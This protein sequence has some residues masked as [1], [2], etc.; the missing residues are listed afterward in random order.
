MSNYFEF[1][2]TLLHELYVVGSITKVILPEWRYSVIDVPS[3]DGDIF[4]GGKY[5]PLEYDITILVHGETVL[6]Y[7]MAKSDL[8]DLLNVRNPVSIKFNADKVGYGMPTSAVQIVDKSMTDGLAT[9]HI[10]CFSPFFYSTE[11]KSFDSDP[12]ALYPLTITN[13]GGEPVKPFMQVG[14]SKDSNFVQLENTR[15]GERIL[16]GNY[17]KLNLPSVTRDTMVLN[18]HCE[19]TASWSASSASIDADRTSGGTIGITQD[20]NCI[21]IATLPSSST[22]TWKGTAV[23]QNLDHA[24]D[25]FDLYCRMNHKSTGKNGDPTNV[26]VQTET[27]TSGTKETYY[28]VT[29]SS[30]NVRKGAGTNHAKVAT[31]SKGYQIFGA[32]V[33]K[34]WVKF[35]YPNTATGVYRYCSADYVTKKVKDNT[36]TTTKENWVTT[37]PTPIRADAKITATNKGAIPAGRVVR[38]IS[39]KTYSHTHGGKTYQFFKLAV[40]WESGGK[41]YDGYVCNGNIVRGDKATIEY[42][43]SIITNSA[44]DKTGLIELYGFSANGTKLFKIGLIDDNKWY[45]YTCPTFQI[46][47][48][49]VL[50]DNTKVP[51]PKSG[52]TSSGTADSS[53]TVKVT[54]Y[55]SGALGNWNDFFGELKIK[56]T[57]DKAG[58]YIW[59]VKCNK[60]SAGVIVKSMSK[61]G[62]KG[63][64]PTDALSYVVCY[65]G[66]SGELAKASDVALTELQIKELNAVDDTEQN[67]VRFHAGD[68]IDIDF[69]NRDVYCNG[70]NV[71]YLVDIGSRFF[72]VEGGETPINIFSDDDNIVVGAVINEKYVGS[73]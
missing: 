44:D 46:G 73:D 14:F 69:E 7:E 67:V 9:I 18:D 50:K 20:G 51:P 12:S 63:N 33:S 31:L 28:E 11:F 40:P 42:D 15:T 65:M 10:V 71:N 61:T 54:N 3:R 52:A 37:M 66:T 57:K 30:L 59:E 17:P 49:V 47:N 41:K 60:L 53:T 23:R 72:S 39:S 19:S 25:E 45:E 56:R 27:S 13:E 29:A 38:V 58:N 34:G 68:V 55:L 5:A 26:D 22:T 8:R 43:Q 48:T 35:K 62:I 16:I 4:D 6:D 70:D 2:G 32:T 24:V 21:C 36:V 1:N 64:Y